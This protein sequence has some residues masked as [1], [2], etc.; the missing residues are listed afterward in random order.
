[1]LIRLTVKSKNNRINIPI[2]LFLQLKDASSLLAISGFDS[3]DDNTLQYFFMK[4]FGKD[5]PYLKFNSMSEES[6]ANLSKGL[7]NILNN[8]IAE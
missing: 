7:I 5:I 6:K 1:M 8:L 3:N 4:I 2:S